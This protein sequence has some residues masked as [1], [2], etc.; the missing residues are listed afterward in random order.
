MFTLHFV[1][2]QLLVHERS[3]GETV[4]DRI[5][6]QESRNSKKVIACDWKLT[7]KKPQR[8][9]FCTATS[10]DFQGLLQF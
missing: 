1:C 2:T 5:T 3:S 8:N 7:A 10:M 4:F 6:G 9:Q